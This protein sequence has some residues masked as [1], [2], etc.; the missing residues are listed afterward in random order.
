MRQEMQGTMRLYF[1]FKNI[2]CHVFMLRVAT[3]FS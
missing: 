1:S 2:Y 3:I